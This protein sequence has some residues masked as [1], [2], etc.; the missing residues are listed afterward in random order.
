[1]SG[2]P[3]RGPTPCK[4]TLLWACVSAPFSKSP[5]VRQAGEEYIFRQSRPHGHGYE[6]ALQLESLLC[7]SF[8]LFTYFIFLIQMLFLEENSLADSGCFCC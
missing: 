5:V 8:P 3:R 6:A 4:V 2:D 7:A 1:M